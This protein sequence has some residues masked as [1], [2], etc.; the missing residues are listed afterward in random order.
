MK[1]EHLPAP[2]APPVVP[3]S[4]NMSRM[5]NM[6][7]VKASF[8]DSNS[9]LGERK[10]VWASNPV[11]ATG[12]FF[13]GGIWAVNAGGRHAR[14]QALA[15]RVT[16]AFSTQN[17]I[18][19]TL[20]LNLPVA[21]IGGGLTL[22]SKTRASALGISDKEARAL[23]DQIEAVWSAWANSALES[24]LTG[25]NDV[26]QLASAAFRQYL[27]SG[28][29]LALIEW[30]EVSHA[31][32][33]TKIQLLDSSQLDRTFTKQ[34]GGFKF[35]N[36]VG[37]DKDGRVAA[38]A[39]RQLDLGETNKTPEIKIVP[40]R[41]SW[42]RQKVIHLFE[43][44]DPRAVRGLSPLTPS[45]TSAA[46]ADTLG[47]LEIAKGLL[48][49]GAVFNIQSDMPTD[50]ASDMLSVD[51][52]KSGIPVAQNL[53]TWL[54]A[55]EAYYSK[56]KIGVRSGQVFHTLPG[57]R[58]DLV[59][60]KAPSGLFADVDAALVRKAAL[61]A[62]SSYESVSGSYKDTSF[63]AS[64]LATALP[65][66]VNLKRRKDI[67]EAFYKACFAAVM[68]EFV[69]LGDIVL[70]NGVDFYEHREAL[71]NCRFLGKGR[72]SPD[73]L[74][75]ANAQIRRLE[76]GLASLTEIAAEDGADLESRMEALIAEREWM[77]SVGLE[78]PYWVAQ[79]QRMQRKAA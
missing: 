15:S 71:L 70:P 53:S 50:K 23:S 76:N 48:H 32:T 4:P 14:D 26:H 65:H 64:R 55:K 27:A 74:K 49:A 73:E 37:F 17:P 33:R 38:Y 78:H 58:L 24:D 79:Q 59:E 43:N 36:G 54:D 2:A 44:I 57:E 21:A 31:R 16:H 1:I 77:Q 46:E 3:A 68:E 13:E 5:F 35:V 12:G 51:D 40:A 10:L 18:I 61:A 42:G 22:S 7:P 8:M 69:A 52:A 19:A 25:R 45:L 56:A 47:E 75:T 60:S 29:C 67:A 34:E 9:A 41:T 72:V 6:T 63:S 28:E 20:L 66:E 39:I 30:K 62:G 11:A